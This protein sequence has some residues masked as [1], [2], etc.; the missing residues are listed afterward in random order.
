MNIIKFLSCNILTNINKT[1]YDER[2][3]ISRWQ[4][5]AAVSYHQGNQQAADTDFR[6]TDDLLSHIGADAGGNKGNTYYLNTLRPAGIQETAGRRK[7]LR[8]E[9]RVRGA[10]IARRTGAGVHYRG[11]VYR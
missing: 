1:Y 11:E 9:V 6:Q 10:A 7:R 4:R 5:Y 3:R 8:R 2:N